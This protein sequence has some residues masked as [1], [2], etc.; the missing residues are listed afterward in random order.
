MFSIYGEVTVFI[1]APPLWLYKKALAD[2]E[3]AYQIS[4]QIF[5]FTM[6][7]VLRSIASM[8]ASK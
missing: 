6:L 2:I 5:P 8:C 3:F 7:D 4:C 1:L